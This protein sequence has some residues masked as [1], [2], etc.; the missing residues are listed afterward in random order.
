MGFTRVV[1]PAVN[2]DRADPTLQE[3]GCE[4]VGVRTVG[5]ALD[6]LLDL[7]FFARG[8]KVPPF[9]SGCLARGGV[10][11]WF[12][13]ARAGLCRGGRLFGISVPALRRGRCSAE[14]PVRPRSRR[15]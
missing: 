12:I 11:A 6:Q 9:I 15:C 8:S 3:D 4:L 5:E 7:I 14:C 10:M 13:L 1:M 2:V